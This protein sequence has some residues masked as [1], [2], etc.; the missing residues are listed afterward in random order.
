MSFK[1]F[2]E[3]LCFFIVFLIPLV[4][5]YLQDVWLLYFDLSGIS[6]CLIR[7]LLL[8]VQIISKAVLRASLSEKRV[9]IVG[10]STITTDKLFEKFTSFLPMQFC[11]P[12][13]CFY[14]DRYVLSRHKLRKSWNNVFHDSQVLFPLSG[15]LTVFWHAWYLK[16]YICSVLF[17][18]VHFESINL[19]QII[20]L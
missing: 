15:V 5:T 2:S 6:W 19:E 10:P 13:Q 8:L 7:L 16:I 4:V 3:P 20:L 18:L 9:W 17:V 14:W 12:N 1:P 11:C